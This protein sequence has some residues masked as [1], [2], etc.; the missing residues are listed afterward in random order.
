V[1][2]AAL[3]LRALHL[4]PARITPR[5]LAGYGLTT[6]LLFYGVLILFDWTRLR[7]WQA[8]L[9]A[10]LVKKEGLDGR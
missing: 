7:R 1:I 8:L 9:T 5:D 6:L 3:Y 2:D 4:P 10:R